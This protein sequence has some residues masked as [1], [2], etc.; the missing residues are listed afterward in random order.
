MPFIRICKLNLWILSPLLSRSSNE[1]SGKY[2]VG[3]A[4]VKT[5]WHKLCRSGAIRIGA[6]VVG[7][8][9]GVSQ[10]S[11]AIRVC[12]RGG[13]A[14]RTGLQG[15][16]IHAGSGIRAVRRHGPGRRGGIQHG[17]RRWGGTAGGV[18]LLIG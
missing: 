9:C 13:T 10:G 12:L 14:F 7:L 2:R 4:A 17:V 8:R 16:G 11:V 3:E 6:K 15:D 1:L 5:F 18:R